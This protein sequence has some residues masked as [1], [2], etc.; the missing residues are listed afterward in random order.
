MMQSEKLKRA[1]DAV[2]DACGK[3]AIC[4][5]DCPI[6]VARKALR[7]LYTDVLDYERSEAQQ[8]ECS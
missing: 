4:S 1:L 6:A 2:E 7:G 5:P 8:C 3:C